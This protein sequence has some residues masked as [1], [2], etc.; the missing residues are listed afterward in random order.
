MSNEPK[1]KAQ[2]A[3][4]NLNALL[5]TLRDCPHRSSSRTVVSNRGPGHKSIF[6]MRCPCTQLFPNPYWFDGEDSH[7]IRRQYSYI[8]EYR[9][10]VP[11][12]AIIKYEWNLW[13][14]R[15]AAR[16]VARK[17]GGPQKRVP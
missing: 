12:W 13:K 2:E 4:D 8:C 6:T 17:E 3:I 1:S 14:R 15:R 10:D 11:L 16:L 5:N 7:D 9:T